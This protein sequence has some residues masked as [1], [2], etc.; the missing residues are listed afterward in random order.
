MLMIQDILKALPHRY[1]FLM[2][3]RI[4]EIEYGKRGKGLK[5]VTIN[6]EYFRGHFPENPIVPG[7]FILEALVQLSGIVAFGNNEKVKGGVLSSLTYFKFIKPVYPGDQLILES[8]VIKMMDMMC[9]AAVVAK[10]EGSAVA[11]GEIIVTGG[12]NAFR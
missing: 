3:D 5:N 7:V 12:T 8:E 10:V 2:V 6:E 1:P 11:H 4:L 9:K